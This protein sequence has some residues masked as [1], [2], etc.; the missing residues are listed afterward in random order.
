MTNSEHDNQFDGDFDDDLQ[1]M[2]E[3]TLEQ[4][5]SE[6]IKPSETPKMASSLDAALPE[7]E[8]IPKPDEEEIMGL[9]DIED[10]FLVAGFD[11]IVD[12]NSVTGAEVKSSEQLAREIEHDGMIID[13]EMRITQLE[14]ELSVLQSNADYT[15]ALSKVDDYHKQASN[16]L[17]IENKKFRFFSLSALVLALIALL[18]GGSIVILNSDL[19]S[20]IVQV[21]NTV[22]DIENRL[23]VPIKDP[24]NEKIESLQES[25]L[26]LENL[27]NKLVQLNERESEELTQLTEDINRQLLDVNE[28][29]QHIEKKM[30]QPVVV[31]RKRVDR[32]TRKAVTKEWVVNLV[33]HKQ[34]WYA[35]KK[36]EEFKQK[37]VPVEIFPVDVQG[38]EWFRIRVVGFKDK[39][40]AALYAAKIKKSLNLGSVWVA[41]K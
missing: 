28:K 21:K 5:E 1:K 4:K 24:D 36:A 8:H 37:G 17:A 19:Q 33:S 29:V 9:E 7:Q 13:Q 22:L 10:D 15:E 18:V 12:D 20:H 35:D 38:V 31:K 14:K 32:K 6:G 16:E 41:K 2:L 26:R 23:A 25:V 40:A 34:R 30:T 11:T 3:D 27:T 39:E